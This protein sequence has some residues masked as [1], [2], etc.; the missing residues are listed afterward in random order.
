MVRPGGMIY[1][2]FPQPGLNGFGLEPVMSF[3]SRVVNVKNIKKGK[4][5]K[6]SA[7]GDDGYRYPAFRPALFVIRS[8]AVFD[9]VVI[10]GTLE[11]GWAK[12][13]FN[14]EREKFRKQ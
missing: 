11:E 4:T 2:M 8:E 12:G 14:R 10:E 5:L 1:G 6:G 9:R 13:A 7:L 3:K